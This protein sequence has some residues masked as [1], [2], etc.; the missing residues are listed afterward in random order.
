MAPPAS[1]LNVYSLGTSQA[2]EIKFGGNMSFNYLISQCKNMQT[3][4][5]YT[6]LKNYYTATLFK[7]I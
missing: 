6:M 1:R 7:I 2:L 5:T 4:I 3:R